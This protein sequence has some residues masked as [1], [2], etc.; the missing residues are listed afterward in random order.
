MTRDLGPFE[1]RLPTETDDIA[2][3]VRGILAIQAKYASAQRR[4]LGRGTHTKAIGCAATFEVFDLS[5]TVGDRVLA[6]RLARGLYAHPGVYPATVRFANARSFLTRDSRKDVRALSFSIQCPPGI[7]GPE[8]TRVDYSMNNGTTF[9]LNDAHA[10]ATLMRFVSAKGLFGLL[11]TLFTTAPTDVAGLIGTALRGRRAEQNPVR[12]YQRM[13]Y[14]STV[15][16]SHGASD[17]VKYS[18]I[19]SPENEAHALSDGPN[20]LADELR[21]HVSSGERKSTFDLA[22]QFLDAERMTYKGQTREPSFWIEN[23]SVEWNEAEAPFHVVGRLTLTADSMQS[24]DACDAQYIDVT[25]HATPDSR[26]LGSINRARWEAESASRQ[27]RLGAPQFDPSLLP[28]YQTR[29]RLRHLARATVIG[30]GLFLGVTS[31]LSMLALYYPYSQI[32][33]LETVNA[34]VYADQGWGSGL[35]AAERQTYYYTPQGAGLKDMRYTWF[36]QLEMPWGRQK[37]ADPDHLRRYGF[38]VDPQ[39]SHNPDQLPVGFTKHFDAQLNEELLD[40]TCAACHTGQLHITR[41]GQTTAVRIDGGQAMH[42]FTTSTVGHFLPMMMASLTSTAINPIK[43]NRFANQVLGEGRGGRLA[44]HAELRQVIAGFLKLAWTEKS[45]HLVPT[46]EGFGRTDALARISNT[47]FGDNLSPANYAVGNGPVNYPPIWNIWKFDWVQYN[48]SVSQP[49]ARNLGEAMGVGARYALV[50]RY[51]RPLPPEQRFRSSAMVD[52]LHTIELTLRRLQ[53][54]AW[55]SAQFGAIDVQKAERGKALFNDHCVSCH[56]PHLAPPA[57]KARN[58]PLKT[59]ADPE[60]IMK[61]L[62]VDDIGTDPNTA[63]NFARATVDLT[64]S[65][66]TAEDLRRVARSNLEKFNTRQAAYLRGEIARLQTAGATAPDAATRIAAL[67]SQLSGLDAATVQQLSQ[68]DPR[69]VPVGDALSYLGTMIREKAYLDLRYTPEEQADRDGF[70]MLDLPQVIAGYKPRPLAGIWATPPYLHNG[71]VPTIY[72]LLSPVAERPATFLVGSREFD[73]QH[74][75][76]AKMTGNGFEFNTAL[77]GNRNT[78]H[79]FNHGYTPW[80]PGAPPAQG[81]IGPW[82]SPDDR[83][84]IIEHLKVRND[85]VDG[86]QTPEVPHSEACSIPSTAPY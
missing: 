73:P 60:W 74:V 43:F 63:V 53:P 11:K 59:A 54:P 61:T 36:V 79:E 7:A 3:I 22:L 38:I 72:D 23:A 62:C 66:L 10:F 15:P 78:G 49:M 17:A 48:A 67:T 69:R 32:P 51:G 46:E 14:W 85:D 9:P 33:P 80:T 37:F 58:A 2:A 82:L 16:F 40:V 65:G 5:V 71:A 25:E 84:A 12:P 1:R 28:E 19:P 52:N 81:L 77:S 86:P 76:L 75:G 6:T 31:L 35:E 55:P 57:L 20:A 21:R 4:A 70:G 64:R 56:G 30:T 26:P 45:K 8:G 18:A 68:L 42:A 41:N 39:T 44:L 13:R 34:V 47:V 27:A 50:D 29:S 83:L 24:A